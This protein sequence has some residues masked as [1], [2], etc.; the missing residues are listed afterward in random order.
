MFENETF[1]DPTC[2]RVDDNDPRRCQHIHGTKQC[3]LKSLEGTQKCQFHT[4][5]TNKLRRYHLSSMY[6]RTGDL[7]KDPDFKSIREEVA[8]L[9]FSLE[10]ILNKLEG[11]SDFLI[12]A[13]RIESIIE[14]I[15]KL[16]SM[17]QRLETL[18]GQMLDKTTLLIFVDEIIK[19]ISE[20]VTDPEVLKRTSTKIGDCVARCIERAK[21]QTQ[22]RSE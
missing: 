11:P 9:R 4:P 13:G 16:V 3:S 21:S 22:E 10:Q 18:L 7:L 19:V 15:A 12:Y 8:I 1:E 20:E 14:K 2:I 5:N 17:S 6:A